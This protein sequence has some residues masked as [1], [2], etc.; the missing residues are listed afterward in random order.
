MV[1][2]QR[3]AN[4]TRFISMIIFVGS[5]LF[6]YAYV[7]DATS[8]AVENDF[9]LMQLPKG[10]IFYSMLALFAVFNILMNMGIRM[11][12]E[13]RG[14][15]GNSRLFYSKNQKEAI[16]MWTNLLVAGFNMLLSGL[17]IYVGFMRIVEMA[18][19]GGQIFIPVLAI[20]LFLVPLSGLGYTLF[21]RR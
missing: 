15:D 12:R 3:L 5:L 10:L 16:L 8:R 21:T 17:L 14:A 9:Y 19:V 11:Y 2:R 13:S 6:F 18:S 1:I 20:L 7:S 4:I